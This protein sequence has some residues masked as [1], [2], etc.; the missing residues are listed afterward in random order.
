METKVKLSEVT[1][2]DLQAITLKLKKV[3]NVPTFEDAL[4]GLVTFLP[5]IT[6]REFMA[7]KVIIKDFDSI[8]YGDFCKAHPELE[9]DPS[10]TSPSNIK[11][12][13]PL[14]EMRD[15]EV[16]MYMGLTN[17]PP[18]AKREIEAKTLESVSAMKVQKIPSYYMTRKV[19]LQKI[20]KNFPYY[21]ARLQKIEAGLKQFL[22]KPEDS[23]ARIIFYCYKNKSDKLLGNIMN[24]LEFLIQDTNLTHPSN[25]EY[26]NKLKSFANN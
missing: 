17:P 5:N 6:F 21:S 1:L 3:N 16:K 4:D 10:G 18:S 8:R 7:L 25:V 26:L 19:Y 22:D 23:L 15:A 2:H 12:W 11:F 14:L 9:Y 20:S 13:E 24:R